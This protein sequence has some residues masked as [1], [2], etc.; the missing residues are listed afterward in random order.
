[1]DFGVVGMACISLLLG[2]W[3]GMAYYRMRHIPTVK[4]VSAYAV[5]FFVAFVATYTFPPANLWFVL[6]VLVMY[7]GLRWVMKPG[8]LPGAAVAV[9]AAAGGGGAG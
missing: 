1:M 8:H 5:M 7:F 2:L 6:N 4:S 3:T 9:P